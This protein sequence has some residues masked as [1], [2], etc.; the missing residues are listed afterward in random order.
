MTDEQQA[1]I[2]RLAGAICIETPRHPNFYSKAAYVRWDLVMR[3]R[4]AM[5]AAGF[6]LEAARTQ[7]EKS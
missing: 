2:N 6:D 3:L 4:D 1:V 5:T 7:Y